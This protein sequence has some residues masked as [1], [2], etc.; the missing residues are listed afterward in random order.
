MGFRPRPGTGVQLTFGPDSGRLATIETSDGERV[1]WTWDG[2]LLVAERWT[3]PVTGEVTRTWSRDFRVASETVAV[4][5]EGGTDSARQASAGEDPVPARSDTVTFS[6]DDDGLLVRAGQLALARNLATG[7]V[8]ALE[9]GGVSDRVAWS[10]YGEVS[11]YQV[12]AGGESLWAWRLE[13]DVLGRVVR[14]TEE[15]GAGPRV[16]EYIYDE[17]DRLSGVKEDGVRTWTFTYDANGNRVGTEGPEGALSAE[18]DEQDRLVRWGETRYEYDAHGRLTTRTETSTGSTTRYR[19]DAMGALREVLLPDGRRVTYGVDGLGRR[20]ERRVD[21]V[22]T[23]AF[24]YRGPWVVGVLDGEGRLVQRFVYGARPHVPDYLVAYDAGVSAGRLYRLETDHLGSVRLVVDAATGEVVQRLEYD[25]WGRVEEDT[26]PGFQPFGFA[27]GLYDPVTGLVRFG[28]RDYDPEVGR[29][30]SRDPILFAGGDT[31]L[32]GYVVNDP[33]NWVD[34]SGTI[35]W[36]PVA[37]KIAEAIVVAFV[38]LELLDLAAIYERTRRF[39]DEL[40]GNARWKEDAMRHCVASCL[41]TARH[42]EI[43]AEVTG[44]L[45]ENFGDLVMYDPLGRAM[46]ER[47]NYCGRTMGTSNP[48]ADYE[49]CTRECEAAWY[50][51]RLQQ[52]P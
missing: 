27:G 39:T 36:A 20:V 8:E 5:T 42:A 26:S 45:N 11:D 28:V 3:G 15:G 25:P 18:Y 48:D 9:L 16:T 22:L 10:A 30:H 34:P 47:N 46:D 24:L 40:F 14:R 38:G 13:R 12:T 1:A 32:Y 33:V 6:Y 37:W 23:H 49:V 44:E 21:G 7:R 43:V 50:D 41:V 2:P 31:N 29:W 52:Y 17:A 51:G 19:H 35:V 4:G